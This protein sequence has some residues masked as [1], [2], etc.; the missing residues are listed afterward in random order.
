MQ[1]GPNGVSVDHSREPWDE[2]FCQTIFVHCRYDMLK[3]THHSLSVTQKHVAADLYQRAKYEF[4]MDAAFGAVDRVIQEDVLEALEDAVIEAGAD[5]IIALPHP[6]FDDDDAIDHD[7]VERT[8]PS[9]ALPFAYAEFLAKSLGGERDSRIVQSARVGRTKLDTF[10]R[11]LCQP[12]FV[13]DIDVDRPYIMADDVVTTG[14]TLAALRSYIV[15]SGGTVIGASALAHKA[16]RSQPL[17]LAQQTLRVLESSYSMEI[18]AYWRE[19]FGHGLDCLTENEGRALADWSEQRQRE[20]ISAGDG[21]L[22]RLRDRVNK[23][24]GKGG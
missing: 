1:F 24:A 6:A 18:H 17:P 8:A 15:R 21:L 9:N 19:T 13:G 11:F 14:G 16:G 5:P 20:G 7:I 23:A 4:D 10:L 3:G 2:G 22:R 12:S